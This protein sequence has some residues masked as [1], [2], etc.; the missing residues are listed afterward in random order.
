MRNQKMPH[1]GLKGLRV[2][3]DRFRVTVGIVQTASAPVSASA[4]TPSVVF[5]CSG[6]IDL[7]VA[8]G[9]R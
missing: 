4:T 2:R 9:L 1:D 8:K 3:R 7:E 5:Y 6:A